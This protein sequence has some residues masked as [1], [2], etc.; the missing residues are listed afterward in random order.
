MLETSYFRID[1]QLGVLTGHV[2]DE[3]APVQV[4]SRRRSRLDSAQI[5][6]VT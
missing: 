3:L 6:L 4:L 1:A 5:R 2:P